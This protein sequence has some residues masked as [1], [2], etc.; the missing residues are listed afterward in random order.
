M[1]QMHS[2]IGDFF[3]LDTA[4]QE[5]IYFNNM[6]SHFGASLAKKIKDTYVLGLTLEFGSE[7]VKDIYKFGNKQTS[8]GKESNATLLHPVLRVYKGGVPC[9][10]IHFDEDIFADFTDVEIYRMKLI[11]TLQMFL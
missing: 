6:N 1:Y 4:K 11:R 8:L 2:I 9:D 7:H 10:E 3:W 5:V